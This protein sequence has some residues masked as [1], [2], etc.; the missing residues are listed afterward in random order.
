MSGAGDER[1]AELLDLVTAIVRDRELRPV[2]TLETR[3][4]G[5]YAERDGLTVA[6][7]V[8]DE[9]TVIVGNDPATVF[10][11]LEVELLGPGEHADLEHLVGILLEAGASRSEGAPKLLRALDVSVRNRPLRPKRKGSP[12]EHVRAG[13]ADQAFALVRRDPGTRLGQDPEE[14]HHMRVAVRRSRAILRSARPLLEREWADGLRAELA[15]IG[16]EL[17]EVRD[18]DVLT[19]YLASQIE[20]L[21]EAERADAAALAASLSDRH[22]EVRAQLLTALRS[23]RYLLLLEAMDKAAEEPRPS[24]RTRSLK[25]IAASEHR[26]LVRTI[27]RLGDDPHDAALHA[28]RIEAKR[29]RY[30][31]ELAA[32]AVGARADRYV[33]ACKRLQD[34]LGDHQDA[35]VAEEWIEATARRVAL[36]ERSVPI[37][38]AAGRLAQLQVERRHDARRAWRDAWKSVAREGRRAWS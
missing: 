20:L 18:L 14:L 29:A 36:G 38:F 27:E 7:V 22:R 19:A 8:R 31:G 23:A 2:A 33:D 34:V 26:K 13:L 15:W 6:E 5:V 24:G 16:A 17:G 1:P 3:R 32:R 37:A 25:T 9:V 10:S 28:A 21:P 30:A 35:V 12:L 4:A 11:E